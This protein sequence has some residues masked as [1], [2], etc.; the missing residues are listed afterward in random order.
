WNS[1]WTAVAA[2]LET[3]T[4]EMESVGPA[5]TSRATSGR[6]TPSPEEAALGDC[7]RAGRPA[8]ATVEAEAAS[9]RAL[10]RSR[11]LSFMF[12][13]AIFFRMSFAGLEKGAAPRS[14]SGRWG[15]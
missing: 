5:P 3:A 1:T 10:A 9:K 4:H 15:N 13:S 11:I 14:S 8:A 12:P 2:L 7:G 6:P